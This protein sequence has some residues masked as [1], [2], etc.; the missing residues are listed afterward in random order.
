MPTMAPIAIPAISPLL[1]PALMP[2]ILIVSQLPLYGLIDAC[3]AETGFN[4]SG[5]LQHARQ[6]PAKLKDKTPQALTSL[7]PTTRRAAPQV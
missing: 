5:T 4:D 3:T 6:A 1:I 2:R 7:L